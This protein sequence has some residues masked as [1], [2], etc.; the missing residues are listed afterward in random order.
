MRAAV[1]LCVVCA[2]EGVQERVPDASPSRAGA[3]HH[4]RLSSKLGLWMCCGSSRVRT[5]MTPDYEC[6]LM[7]P[8]V[9][10]VPRATRHRSTTTQHSPVQQETTQ[11][12]QQVQSRIEAHELAV[13]M[14]RYDKEL[15]AFQ[16]EAAGRECVRL[17]VRA[18][19]RLLG[20][21][22]TTHPLS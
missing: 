1:G 5:S 17:Q 11:H 20:H 18:Q 21:A 2:V 9:P 14:A 10:C 22:S 7:H 19:L 12:P 13:R 16:L 6:A 8:W 15:L 4:A 3:M